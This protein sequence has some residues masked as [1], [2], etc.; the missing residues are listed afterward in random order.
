MLPVGENRLP[1]P[2]HPVAADPAAAVLAAVAGI[3]PFKLTRFMQ[4]GC[5]KKQPLLFYSSQIEEL[6]DDLS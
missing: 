4:S 1:P 6:S 2:V 3:D 5:R